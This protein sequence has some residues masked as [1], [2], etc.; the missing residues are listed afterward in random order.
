M[1]QQNQTPQQNQQG[2]TLQGPDLAIFQAGMARGY[3]DAMQSFSN[4]F[5]AQCDEWLKKYGAMA[6]QDEALKEKIEDVT[7]WLNGLRPL[8]VDYFTELSTKANEQANQSVNLA[9]IAA[10][11]RAR[12]LLERFNNA[13]L[14]A[15]S[16][17]KG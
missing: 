3:A 13:M 11:G 5:S 4:L 12:T 8:V 9:V 2:F 17:W 6:E 14:G 1:E 10:S 15:I 7:A 16:G